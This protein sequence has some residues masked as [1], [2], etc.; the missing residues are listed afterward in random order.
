MHK[1]EP[2]IGAHVSTSGGLYKAVERVHAIGGNCLQIFAS[3]PRQWRACLPDKKTVT[4]YQKAIKQYGI[5]PVFIHAPYLINLASPNTQTRS[6]S[7][8]NLSTQMR[9]AELIQARGVIFH[10]G[11]GGK[12]LPRTKAQRNLVEGMKTV[13]KNTPDSTQLIMENSAGG[14]HRIG[15]TIDEIKTIFDALDSRRVKVCFDTAHALE[16]G[17]T[18]T[19]TP[20]NVKSLLKEWREKIGLDNIVAIHAN[21]SKTPFNSYHD[22]HENI[23]RGYIG[24]KAFKNLAQIDELRGKPWILEVPGFNNRGPDQR[25]IKL[26][27][28]CFQG[29]I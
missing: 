18:K 1:A 20:A 15:N 14:G 2:K 19:Y 25:N 5:S 23:G 28:K 26:L 3:S 16:A 22:R 21:D 12:N 8:K 17:I 7:I 6:K 27:E 4:K 10:L 9:I 13:L 24:L 11:S 29:K